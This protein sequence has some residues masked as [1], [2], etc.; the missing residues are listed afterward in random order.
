MTFENHIKQKIYAD[1]SYLKYRT[2]SVLVSVTL[3]YFQAIKVTR[4]AC[5]V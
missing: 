4:M 1:D 3:L 5:T 2:M